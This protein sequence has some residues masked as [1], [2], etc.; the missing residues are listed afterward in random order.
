MPIQGPVQ[1]VQYGRNG[2]SG[3]KNARR[4]GKAYLA[5]EMRSQVPLGSRKETWEEMAADSD[6]TTDVKGPRP[7]SSS[8]ASDAPEIQTTVPTLELAKLATD[9]GGRHSRTRSTAARTANEY[10]G[11]NGR[12]VKKRCTAYHRRVAVSAV[13]NQKSPAPTRSTAPVQRRLAATAGMLG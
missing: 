2:G 10:N 4:K 9:G 5:D 7:R 6:P 13:Q 3:D 8:M 12:S 1:T 11:C